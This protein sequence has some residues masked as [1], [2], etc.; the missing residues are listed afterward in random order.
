MMGNW[1][2]LLR[3]VN[4]GGNNKLPMATLRSLAE[5]EGFGNVRTYI[6]SGNLTLTSDLDEAGIRER[7]EQAIEREFG[8]RIA[9]L[10]RSGEEMADTLMRNPFADHPGNKVVAIFTDDEP[11]AEGLLHQ[12][13]EEV[14][15]GKREIFAWYPSGQGRS[16]LGIPGGAN[17]TARNMN[18]VAKLAE[19][20]A[21]TL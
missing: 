7:L 13:D 1:V 18:T 21:E 5:A 4:V 9:V 11:S 3:G 10:V 19:M 17:G 16:K 12:V 20:A 15:A 2:A 14:V 6:A 8:K